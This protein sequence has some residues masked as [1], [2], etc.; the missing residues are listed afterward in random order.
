MYLSRYGGARFSHAD[1]RNQTRRSAQRR[2]IQ[3]KT[4][5]YDGLAFLELDLVAVEAC[6]RS[7]DHACPAKA[8][9]DVGVR[10]YLLEEIRA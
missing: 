4:R 5:P 1:A 7:D 10:V 2:H 8:E 3:D 9:P 6:A